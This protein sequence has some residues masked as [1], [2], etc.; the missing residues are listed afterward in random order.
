MNTLMTDRLIIK[1]HLFSKVILSIGISDKSN[2][3]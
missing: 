1:T 3:S 2:L